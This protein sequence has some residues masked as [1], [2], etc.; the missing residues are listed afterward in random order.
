VIIQLQEKHKKK[1]SKHKQKLADLQ[2]ALKSKFQSE[3]ASHS[4]VDSQ[5]LQEQVKTMRE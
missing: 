1:E 4:Q 2:E 3:L 5:V